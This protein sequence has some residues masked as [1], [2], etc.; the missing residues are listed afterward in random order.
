MCPLVMSPFSHNLLQMQLQCVNKVN[1]YLC[2]KYLHSGWFLD[3]RTSIL[4]PK[5]FP[6]GNVISSKVYSAAFCT[7]H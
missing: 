1:Y 7:I 6:M 2:L 3:G 4:V 5:F